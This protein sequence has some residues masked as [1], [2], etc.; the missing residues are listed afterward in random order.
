MELDTF[1]VPKRFNMPRFQIYDGKSD[2]NFHALAVISFKND[3]DD[4]CP[5]RQSLAKTLP[6]SIKEFMARVEKYVKAEED[7]KEKKTPKPEM[8]NG[9]PKRG[10]GNTGVD[11]SQTR[12][13]AML[14]FNRIFWIP[15]YMVLERIRN[16]PYYRAL[17]KVPD[18][19]MGRSTRKHCAYHNKDG[20]MTQGCRALKSHLEDLVR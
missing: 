5:L 7:I 15:I 4:D 2:P 1:E 9:S 8:R 10:R 3:L 6:K 19:F 18:E 20:H 12:V 16:Q 11:R 13:R 14:T 17:K